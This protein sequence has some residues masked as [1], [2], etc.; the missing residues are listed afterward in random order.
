[1]QYVLYVSIDAG[2]TS[3]YASEADTVELVEEV[4]AVSSI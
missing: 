4:I 2:I 3:I 1:M